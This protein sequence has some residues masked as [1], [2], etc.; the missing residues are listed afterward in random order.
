MSAL[1]N[2]TASS[3]RTK[4][5]L[6]KNE[7]RIEGREAFV[8]SLIENLNLADLVAKMDFATLPDKNLDEPVNGDQEKLLMLP[9]SN[10]LF[11]EY[12][13]VY[14][15]T[16]DGFKIIANVE[17]N[18]IANTARNVMLLQLYGLHLMGRADTTDDE[19]RAVCEYHACY[20]PGNFSYHV[21]GLGSKVV[22]SGSSRSYT[23]KL[24]A[25]GLRA[26]KQFALEIQKR[27]EKG[28]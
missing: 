4:F 24:T 22:R 18:T 26:G 3:D 12:D 10:D 21:K 13:E 6:S 16:S 15:E 27:A 2:D 11:A 25:P 9:S 20:D 19:L 8:E 14:A 1:E 17:E 5:F 23:L 28:G 7:L